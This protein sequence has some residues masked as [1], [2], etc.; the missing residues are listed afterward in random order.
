MSSA[1]FFNPTGSVW[2]FYAG[3]ASIVALPSHTI[4]VAATSAL[5]PTNTTATSAAGSSAP[6]IH[7]HCF[8]LRVIPRTPA[9]DTAE[10]ALTNDLVAFVGG[11]RLQVSLGQVCFFFSASCRCK[12][13]MCRSSIMTMVALTSCSFSSLGN[14]ATKCSMRCHHRMQASCS[15]FSAGVARWVPCSSHLGTRCSS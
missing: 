9:M 3:G 2:G 10:G 4:S 13:E 15:S 14:L 1:A 8:E 11:T 5:G 6:P 12:R 7:H